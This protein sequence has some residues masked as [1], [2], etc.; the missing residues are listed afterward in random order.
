MP[1]KVQA[2]VDTKAEAET[3]AVAG[4]EPKFQTVPPPEEKE[5]REPATWDPP[6]EDPPV[7]EEGVSLT[8]LLPDKSAKEV[9]FSQKPLGLDFMKSMPLTVKNV[10]SGS[11][12]E[13]LKVEKTWVITHVQGAELAGELTGAVTQITDAMAKLPIKK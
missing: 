1:L 8:F 2:L 13:N 7:E 5:T 12:A 10:K 3:E 4:V 9:R 11:I 6:V